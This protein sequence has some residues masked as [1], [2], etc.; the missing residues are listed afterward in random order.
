[1]DIRCA[2]VENAVNVQNMVDGDP[3]TFYFTGFMGSTILMDFGKQVVLDSFVFIPRNDDNFIRPG[4]EYELFYHGG[5]KGWV[6]LGRKIARGVSLSYVVPRGAL[7]HL[8]CLTR[9]KE[10][11]VFQIEKGKQVFI[12][13]FD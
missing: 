11:Q 1:M 3:L 5:R 8:R 12:S 4:D 7:F 2:E 10:E 9:G 13:N 6:S